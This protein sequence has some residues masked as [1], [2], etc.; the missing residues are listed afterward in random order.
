MNVNGG[1]KPVPRC[2]HSA[3]L[4]NNNRYLLIYGGK[5]ESA[6]EQLNAS[7]PMDQAD[8]LRPQMTL[9]D[10]M[11]FDF[12]LHQWTAVCQMGSRP[13]PRWSAAINYV[14]ST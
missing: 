10:I 6:Y 9:D 13:E 1:V 5:N 8:S 14:E 7:E 3:Q 2:D 11:L 4:I 12:E